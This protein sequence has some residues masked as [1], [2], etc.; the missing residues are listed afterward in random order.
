MV[1]SGNTILS[2]PSS[3]MELSQ[4]FN[5]FSYDKIN[6][7][8]TIFQADPDSSCEPAS[9][10][11]DTLFEGETLD[12]LTGVRIAEVVTAINQSA[13]KSCDPPPT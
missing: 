9:S 10:Q 3:L 11:L 6:D 4:R 8:R 13:T 1:Y 5:I 12:K 2:L 7:T